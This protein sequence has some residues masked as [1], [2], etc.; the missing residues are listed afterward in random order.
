[1][2]NNLILSRFV[3]VSKDIMASSRINHNRH[4]VMIQP[5][6]NFEEGEGI[7]KFKIRNVE[8]DDFSMSVI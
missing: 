1:M 6:S 2:I 7:Q 4:V 8:D 3:L 5:D